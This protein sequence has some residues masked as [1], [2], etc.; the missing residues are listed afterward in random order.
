MKKKPAQMPERNH[1][2]LFRKEWQGWP[3]FSEMHRT[4]FILPGPKRSICL[5]ACVVLFILTGLFLHG[6]AALAPSSG[7]TTTA[8]NSMPVAEEVAVTSAAFSVTSGD[9][10]SG[11]S[12]TTSAGPPI[13]NEVYS[14]NGAW[15]DTDPRR[16]ATAARTSSC[17]NCA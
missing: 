10:S 3:L 6:S 2:F 5:L 17:V 14:L 16:P 9:A 4:G 8:P 11:T 13:L 1:P 15:K 7:G 12:T